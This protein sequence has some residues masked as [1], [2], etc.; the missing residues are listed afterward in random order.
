MYWISVS[1]LGALVYFYL[2]GRKLSC[3]ME[4]QET[5]SGTVKKSEPGSR[6]KGAEKTVYEALEKESAPLKRH[7]IYTQAIDEA[8][9][10]RNKSKVKRALL[11]RMA[12][13]YVAEFPEIEQAVLAELGDRPKVI[14]VFKQLAIVLEENKS[15]DAAMEICK[16]A[17]SYGLE[18][19]TKTGYAGRIDRLEKKKA[20]K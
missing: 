19:G 20:A 13:E 3:P 4:N 10:Q 9:K 17:I 1:A 5:V 11:I 2:K 6:S 8:Y 16:K 15:W 14:S 12:G 18:D 7:E